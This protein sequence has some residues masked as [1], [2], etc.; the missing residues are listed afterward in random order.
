[1]ILSLIN[2]DHHDI[3]T[4]NQRVKIEK[5]KKQV[6]SSGQNIKETLIREVLLN[7]KR[8][9]FVHCSQRW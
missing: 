3:I 7:K 1:M 4:E 5:V 2:K 9:F 6:I 8:S